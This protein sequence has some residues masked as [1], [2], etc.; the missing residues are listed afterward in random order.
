MP[1][2]SIK[3]DLHLHSTASDGTLS[4]SEILKMAKK[5][6]IG[7][8]A[9]TDHDTIK[10]VAS[11]TNEAISLGLKL[12]Q[13]LE[14]S[15]KHRN[16]TLHILGYGVETNSDFLLKKLQFCNEQRSRRNVKIIK[17]LQNSGIEITLDDMLDNAKNVHSLGR[18]HIA[19]TLMKKGIVLSIQEAFDRFLGTNGSAFVSKEV[20][21][22]KEAIE[23]IKKSGGLAFV[24]HPMTLNRSESELV[25]FIENLKTYGLDGIELYSSYHQQ[26]HVLLFKKIANM[27][28]LKVSAGSDFHGANKPS[29]AMGLCNVGSHVTIDQISEGIV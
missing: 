22:A 19:S 6:G 28:D 16:G 2:D 27:L 23:I 26:K 8:I 7:I 24:A 17:K 12:I 3:V 5:K 13:G 21:S 14:I 29:I 1:Q 9:I 15:S 11:I 4:P 18:P 25:N 20:F 10:G